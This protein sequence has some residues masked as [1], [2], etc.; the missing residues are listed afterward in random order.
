VVDWLAAT[1]L[2]GHYTLLSI[3]CIFGLH[4]FYL[5]FGARHHYR[6][7]EPKTNLKNLPR[8]TVQLPLYNEKFVAKRLIDAAVALDYP[9]HLLQIQVLDDSTDETKALVKQAVATYR[10]QGFDIEQVLR[11]DRSGYKA[12]A[13]ADAFGDVKGEFIAVFDAD[14]VPAP[15]LL[16]Q[17]IEHFADPEVGMVQAQWDYLN[18]DSSLLTKVQGLMLDAHFG[19]EQSAR[20]ARDVF[21]NFNG[22]AGLWRRSAIEQAGGWQADTI[23]EDLDLSYR[24]QLLG[25][26]FTYLRNVRCLSELPADMS[27]YKTQQHRWT[28]GGIE[29]MLKLW[30]QIWLAPIKLS[31]R[32]E[33]S[34]HLAS[35]LTHLLILVDC[36][37]FLIPAVMLRQNILPYP[38]LWVDLLMFC[39]GGLSHLYFYLSAQQILG[40]SVIDHLLLVPALMSVTI[41]L[42]RSNG[43]G[44]L[45]ALAGHKSGFVR[46]PKLGVAQSAGS[47]NPS[48]YFSQISVSGDILEC[49]LGALYLFASVW[50]IVN[51]VF[52]ALPFLLMFTFGFLY[53]GTTSLRERLAPTVAQQQEFLTPTNVQRHPT[54]QIQVEERAVTEANCPS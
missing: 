12:G 30:R 1:F 14:F 9:K 19:V 35:N 21:F 46:T 38:P 27:A 3:L 34:L 53:T 24:A 20:F 5:T 52:L 42:S 26:R 47:S 49:A 39:F 45:E 11:D 25:W 44:I 33:A 54:S 50:C 8:L 17:M 22:T 10:D 15:D 36:V 28:K 37:F 32:L 13:M 18:R 23:T 41:G 51:N 40:R 2:V 16:L 4:R 29:V 31:T 43:S 6:R 7:P 48:S